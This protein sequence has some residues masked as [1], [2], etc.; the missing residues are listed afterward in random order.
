MDL[1]GHRLLDELS[2]AVVVT[3]ARLAVIAW[4]PAME[5]LTGV[6]RT[7]ALGRPAADVL[8]FLSEAEPAT[9]LL[10]RAHGGETVTVEVRCRLPASTGQTWLEVR[11]R[12][13]EDP[14]GAPAGIIG[15]HSDVS[16]RRGLGG[17]WP[18]W[19]VAADRNRRKR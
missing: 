7:E 5:R 13:W 4:N 15:I 19:E 14:A 1:F 11:Y 17:V 18:G 3:D 10:A 12:P 16:E 9:T 6:P 2:D 8:A